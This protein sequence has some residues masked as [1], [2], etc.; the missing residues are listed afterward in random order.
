MRKG[1]V[2]TMCL[3]F[4]LIT[5][6]LW[7]QTIA[8]ASFRGIFFSNQGSLLDTSLQDKLGLPSKQFAKE[9]AFM[10]ELRGRYRLKYYIILPTR[11]QGVGLLT[12]ELIINGITYGSKEAKDAKKQAIESDIYLL[13]QRIGLDIT[14]INIGNCYPTVAA[15]FVNSSITLKGVP[16]DGKGED[17]VE[18][19]ETFNKCFPAIGLAGHVRQGNGVF[20]YEAVALIPGGWFADVEGRLYFGNPNFFAGVGFRYED[21][22]VRN[23]SFKRDGAYFEVGYS[24]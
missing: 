22:K 10:S 20:K 1:F 3:L 7:A 23:F 5:G 4:V 2:A 24:F 18:N 13:T 14:S 8:E 6:T 15:H 12:N 17:V 11:E 16:K 21:F 19:S 9:L